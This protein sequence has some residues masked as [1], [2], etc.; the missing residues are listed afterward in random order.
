MPTT[1]HLSNNKNNCQ[2]LSKKKNSARK[3]KTEQKKSEHAHHKLAHTTQA[4]GSPGRSGT[5]LR[6]LTTQIFFPKK[7]TLCAKGHFANSWP[8]IALSLAVSKA[9]GGANS[10]PNAASG[11]RGCKMHVGGED[12]E[13]VTRFLVLVQHL[14]LLVEYW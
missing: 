4:Q 13:H 14:V 3:T 10:A 2:H 6:I 5:A 1:A 8:Q 11:R 12:L 9:P 7:I